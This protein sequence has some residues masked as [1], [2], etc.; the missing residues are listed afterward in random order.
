VFGCIRFDNVD[1]CLVPS[2]KVPAF[3][4]QDYRPGLPIGS[5]VREVGSTRCFVDE[6]GVDVTD[7][8]PIEEADIWA[9]SQFLVT[10]EG[11]EPYPLRPSLLARLPGPAVDEL[12][13]NI[14]INW[15]SAGDG[16]ATVQLLWGGLLRERRYQVI[17]LSVGVGIWPRKPLRNW[18]QYFLIFG[19]GTKSLVDQ[20]TKPFGEM[21]SG[22]AF[23][24]VVFSLP[25]SG[26]LAP[27]ETSVIYA[28]K[29]AMVRTRHVPRL[30]C[31]RSTGETEPSHGF[32]PILRNSAGEF[33]LSKP[34]PGLSRSAFGQLA[35]PEDPNE[36]KDQRLFIA[37]D[38]G[39]TN[40]AVAIARNERTKG[41]LLQ[42]TDQSIGL[43][44]TAPKLDP[45]SL[46]F[47]R[48]G[49]FPMN[50]KP[51]NPLSTLLVQFESSAVPFEGLRSLPLRCI[52]GDTL[53]AQFARSWPS[54]QFLKQ[55][56]KWEPGQ[57]G[58]S[59]RVAFIE[60]LGRMVGW[61]LR[62]NPL[63]SNRRKVD[64]TFTCPLSFS[65]AQRIS[66]DHTKKAFEEAL[67]ACGLETTSQHL[68]V[69][70]SLANLYLVRS[71]P[72][73]LDK[74]LPENRK[75]VIDIGGGSVDISVFSEKVGGAGQ[76]V[77]MFLDSLYI[78]G[79]DLAE[80]LLA[81][82]LGALSTQT[83]RETTQALF[84]QP[85]EG[86][87]KDSAWWGQTVQQLLVLRMNEPGGL[88][89]LAHSL[90]TNDV[91]KGT[92]ADLLVL[93]TIVTVY[94]IR[95]AALGGTFEEAVE[96]DGREVTVRHDI[97]E[98][99]EIRVWFAGLGSN[100]FG[101][102]PT[103]ARFNTRRKTVEHVLRIALDKVLSTDAKVFYEWDAIEG[104]LSVCKG[105]LLVPARET[106][107]ELST[108]FWADVAR[109]QDAISWS[110]RY[111]KTAFRSLDDND[112]R[113]LKM[114][115][116]RKC[117]EASVEAVATTLGL[118]PT[119]EVT[120]LLDSLERAYVDKAD[121]IARGEPDAP[122]HPLR[123]AT[124]AL[125]EELGGLMQ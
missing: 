5:R 51:S 28:R 116:F 94:A 33:A 79:K 16:S 43:N 44:L 113:S 25:D 27:G 67:S 41:D 45:T 54:Q 93:L 62:N 39:T 73:G 52:P 59:L 106:G 74:A 4:G 104:K 6:L 55:E 12:I 61:E 89:R 84:E 72:K 58:E 115:E 49:F 31:F 70:E 63:Y 19:S 2:E 77:V 18:K 112:R 13:R 122:S 57:T 82:R 14:K 109:T 68:P 114:D 99:K 124:D 97:P 11:F 92:L 80:K 118:S 9:P 95:M 101:L 36:E 24:P 76:K 21:S 98:A 119:K 105:A 111:R 40:T 22:E 10:V 71:H 96:K 20:D 120:S 123:G 8:V 85:I 32:V 37:V 81:G 60:T 117:V 1:Y 121:M 86:G 26:D 23:E 75:V 102:C 90:E 66:L 46:S 125:K 69:S 50:K 3:N 110:D 35:L 65:T 53:S 56:F 103:V 64:V 38:F 29:A 34:S 91:A 42:F 47:L 7:A 48:Y 108:I 100:L 83:L 15:K 30:L 17:E 78:G 107:L 87:P 88:E